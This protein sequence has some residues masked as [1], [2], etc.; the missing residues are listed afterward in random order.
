MIAVELTNVSKV[1]RIHREKRD[2]VYEV[3]T[4][5]IGK[6]PSREIIA[7]DDISFSVSQGEMVGIIGPNG[8]GKTTLLRIITRITQPTSGK[9]IVNGKVVPFLQLGSGFQSE[10]TAVENIRLKGAIMGL[11]AK[12]IENKISEILEYAELQKF[13][14][15]PV[16]HFSAGMFARLAFATAIQVEPDILVLDEVLAVGDLAFHKK[17]YQSLLSLRKKGKTIIY[18][19]HN[20]VE[21]EKLCDK[22]ILLHNGKLV[23]SGKPIDITRKYRE[24]IEQSFGPED[25]YLVQ[26]ITEFYRN[27]LEREPDQAGLTDFVFKIKSGKIMLNDVAEILKSSQEYTQKKL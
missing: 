22:A 5:G 18:V 6:D 4:K 1:F 26:K 24:M 21:V 16:K 27:I 10:L 3:V 17:S 14:N 8:S 19:T 2:T 7:L 25:E 12:N 15:V 13:A 9:I 11:S 20:L 23:S